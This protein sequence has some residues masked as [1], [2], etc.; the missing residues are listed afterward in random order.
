MMKALLMGI[1]PPLPPE[2]PMLARPNG[3]SHRRARF[4]E[5]AR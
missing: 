4:R 3:E 2:V 1:L 5:S